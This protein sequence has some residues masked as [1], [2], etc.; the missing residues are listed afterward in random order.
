MTDLKHYVPRCRETFRANRAELLLESYAAMQ[1]L[2]AK[3]DTELVDT[4][5]G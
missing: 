4:R 2:F 3:R 5:R 1:R